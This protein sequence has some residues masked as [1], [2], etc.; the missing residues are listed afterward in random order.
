MVKRSSKKSSKKQKPAD[1]I[2]EIEPVEDVTDIPVALIEIRELAQGIHE[3]AGYM[4]MTEQVRDEIQVR[5]DQILTLVNSSI[6]A[7]KAEGLKEMGLDDRDI[8]LIA[9]GL[10]MYAGEQ[11]KDGHPLSFEDH[12]RVIRIGQALER[13]LP[14]PEVIATVNPLSD[15]TKQKIDA[16]MNKAAEMK[17]SPDHFVGDLSAFEDNQSSGVEAEG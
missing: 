1:P 8:A 10:G 12:S 16:V 6:S 15:N 5:I 3:Q 14:V 7:I 9:F 11:R 2:E 13:L 17:V 4:V